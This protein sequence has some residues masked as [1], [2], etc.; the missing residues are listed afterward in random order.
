MEF[1]LG[2]STEFSGIR[3]Y[4]RTDGNNT[5]GM[6]SSVGIYGKENADDEWTLIK[7]MGKITYKDNAE[8]VA[9]IK[10]DVTAKTRYVR[11]VVSGSGNHATAKWIRFIKATTPFKGAEMVNAVIP[12]DYDLGE[13]AV[14]K[15]T[16]NGAGKI[17]S[18]THQTVELPAEYVTIT[19]D[20]ASISPYYFKDNAYGIG[21]EVPFKLTFAFGPA[22]DF[23]VKV[24][25]VDGY[26]IDLRTG[27]HGTLKATAYN[28]ELDRE[29]DKASGTKVRN[30]DSLTFTA[31]ADEGYEVESWYVR[32][33]TPVY[34]LVPDSEKSK[35]GI[36]ASSSISSD[37]PGKMIDGNSDSATNYWHSD[38]TVTED[39]NGK[40][41]TIPDPNKPYTIELDF[42]NTPEGCIVKCKRLLVHS[43]NRRRRNR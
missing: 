31:I 3:Y 30:T 15:V 4:R 8:T 33:T 13:N 12:M 36:T 11:L 29:E 26:K 10:L 6:W 14:A 21:D 28:A 34:E 37:G 19:D 9:D 16:L 39:E 32:S 43:E 41:V 7:P 27:E 5:A 22:I 42:S 18:L 20:T 24:G 2:E 40:Q 38:Y 1:D 25:E 17:T 23:K 35:W